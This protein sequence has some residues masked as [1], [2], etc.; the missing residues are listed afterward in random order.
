M[1]DVFAPQ[2]VKTKVA[3]DVVVNI[4]SGQTVGLVAG[5]AKIGTVTTD[6]TTHGTSDL[7]AADITKISGTAPTTA[8]KLDVKGA[9]GDVFVRQTSAAN[10]NAAVVGNAASGAS[11]SGNPVK[12]G[13]VFNTSAP[14]L[15]TG[16]R[17]DLQLDSSANLKVNIAAGSASGAVAQGSTTSGQTGSLVQ[18]AVTTAAPTYT[19]G[20]TNPV[21]LATTGALR[22]DL[23]ATSANATALKVDGSAVTQP[24]S[25][26]VSITAN[27]STNVAQINGVTPLM[28]AGNGGTGSLRVNIASDQ[29]TI[30][31]STGL[32]FTTGDSGHLTSAAVAAG[33]TVTLDGNQI[34]SGVGKLFEASVSSSV[35]LKAQLGTWDGTTFVVKRTFFVAANTPF[36]YAPNRYDEITMATGATAKFRWSITNNDNAN[37]ADVYASITHAI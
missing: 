20:N 1:A 33:A 8:G 29:V 15:T 9:D 34:A 22:V 27:S 11:D 7:V 2:P 28:G 14:T 17:G 30:P 24:V 36:V 23:G 3:G 5:A 26:T 4:N 12:A 35:A 32:S 13:G 18:G 19:T 16:Q 37:A 31:V 10:L 21:S 6:Q 25:G